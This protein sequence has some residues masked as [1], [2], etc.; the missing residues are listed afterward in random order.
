MQT[1]APFVI[2]GMPRTGTHYLEELLNLHPNVSSNGELLNPYDTVWPDPDR[3]LRSNRELLEIAY[4]R[5][6]GLKGKSHVTHI[7][8]KINQPQFQERPGF[9]DELTSWPCLKAILLI[10]K[11]TLESLRSL[12]QARQSGQWLKYRGEADLTPPPQINLTINDCETYFK[13][14]DDFHRQVKE[15]FAPENL[16]PIYYENLLT[17]PGPCLHTVWSFLGTPAHPCFYRSRLKRQE[18]RSLPQTVV[19]FDELKRHFS[20]GPYES[21]FETRAG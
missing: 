17:A 6:P 15:S 20:D 16:L 13:T 1:T 2:L 10:R 7:G 4:Q 9:F 14:A 5:Y 11:N 8:C 12:V 3:F 21:F 19:N 18:V